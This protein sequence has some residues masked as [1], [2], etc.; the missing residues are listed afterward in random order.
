MEYSFEIYYCDVYILRE[1]KMNL[2]QK[3]DEYKNYF[4]HE[5]IAL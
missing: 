2:E 4:S 3:Y 1:L 5:N